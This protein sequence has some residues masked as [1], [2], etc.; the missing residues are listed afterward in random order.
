MLC[1]LPQVAK[2]VLRDDEKAV[3]E[4]LDDKLRVRR[5]TNMLFMG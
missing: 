4:K 2:H 5:K 3:P 1:V